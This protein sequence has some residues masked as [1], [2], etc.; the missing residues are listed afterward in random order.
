MSLK[1]ESWF[2]LESISIV[3]YVCIMS[4]Q[5]AECVSKNKKLEEEIVSKNSSDLS[6]HEA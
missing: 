1:S 3:S 5:D 6:R 4:C 2:C